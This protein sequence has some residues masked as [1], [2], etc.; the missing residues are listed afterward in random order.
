MLKCPLP[1]QIRD[2][3]KPDVEDT[4][5]VDSNFQD[6]VNGGGTSY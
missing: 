2:L 6:L 4:L 5:K 1:G 3:A